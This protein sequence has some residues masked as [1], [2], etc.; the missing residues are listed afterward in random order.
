MRNLLSACLLIALSAACNAN[1]DLVSD[2][3]CKSGKKWTGGNAGS[4][5]MHPGGDCIGC[6]VAKQKGPQFLVAGTVYSA[7]GVDEPDDCGGVEGAT[8]SITDAKGNT[9]TLTTN[10]A[11]NFFLRSRNA[12]AIAMPYA[13]TVTYANQAHRMV[14]SQSNGAC[15]ACHTQSGANSAP[16][17]VFAKPAN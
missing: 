16:G 4:D 5:Y 14:S 10:A 1:N 11:G 6:H 17:R 12:S 15:N 9:Q 13:V 2:S 8:V 3:S 7:D